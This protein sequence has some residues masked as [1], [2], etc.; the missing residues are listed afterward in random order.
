MP[1][2]IPSSFLKKLYVRG[3]FKNTS[4]G[5][6]LALRNTLFP[7]TLTGLK[8]LE[9]DGHTL[10]LDHLSIAIGDAAPVRASTISPTAPLAFPFNSTATFRVEDQPLAPGTHRVSVEVNT[11][12]AGEFKVDAEDKI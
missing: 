10:T 1:T 4:N 12:E 6:E 11:K 5:Y 2:I 7:G 3:S 8:S 9:I